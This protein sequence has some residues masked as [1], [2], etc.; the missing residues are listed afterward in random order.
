MTSSHTCP[1]DSAHSAHTSAGKDP[2]LGYP[3]GWFCLGLSRQLPV[4][5]VLPRRL[6]DQDCVV[7]RTQ[8]GVAHAA[9]AH[10]P[11]LGAHLGY[12]GKVEGETLLCP[13]HR[14]GFGPDGT[15]TVAPSGVVPP[16][17][18]LERLPL[19]EVNGLL[20]AWHGPAGAPPWFEP[21]VLAHWH[22]PTAWWC[23]KTLTHAQVVIENTFDYLHLP[24]LHRLPVQR[25]RPSVVD[26][27]TITTRLRIHAPQY[28]LLRRFAN[29]M[30]DQNLTLTGLGLHT[31]E[32]DVPRMGVSLLLWTLPTPIA[33]NRLI[34]RLA[35]AAKLTRHS[36]PP[37][38]VR[39][40]AHSAAERAWARA[41]LLTSTAFARQDI[42]IW[43]HQRYL[44]HPKLAVGE[45]AIGQLRHW[46][47]QFYPTDE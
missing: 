3:M 38:T 4:G 5:G 14:L 20:L 31:T 17:A 23:R 18:R 6:M 39:S 15:C 32:V 12:G 33:P 9:H 11:H 13:F 24:Q 37:T 36:A 40:L 28:P 35:V 1:E 30:T 16:R 44:T 2:G 21:P 46:A 41:F 47:R 29:A 43:N 22:A 8:D 45:E 27:P 42:G 25:P 19:R 34:L 26:G 10:C 7:Y